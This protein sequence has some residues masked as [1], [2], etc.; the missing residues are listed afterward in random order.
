MVQ[1]GEVEFF[2]FFRGVCLS[3][4]RFGVEG[5]YVRR[6]GCFFSIIGLVGEGLVQRIGGDL[7]E[8]KVVVYF[9]VIIC[10]K[11]YVCFVLR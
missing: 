2:F 3:G 10:E 1:I 4:G 6:F 11:G 9:K 5:L 7:F 8:L